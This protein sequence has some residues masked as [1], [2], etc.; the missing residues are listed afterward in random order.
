MHLFCTIPKKFTVQLSDRDLIF[1][2][3]QKSKRWWVEIVIK[4]YIDNKIKSN[5]LLSCTYEDYLNACND[6]L[7]ERWIK[8]SK[9]LWFNYE[10]VKNN[11]KIQFKYYK[12]VSFAINK[13]KR[14]YRSLD[15][16]SKKNTLEKLDATLNKFFN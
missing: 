14:G 16:F 5:T 3:S 7:P 4:S 6:K 13:A 9:R 12:N 1:H 10:T 11:F 8:A 15:R 2:Q